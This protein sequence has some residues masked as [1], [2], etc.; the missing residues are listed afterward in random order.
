MTVLLILP[1]LLQQVKRKRSNTEPVGLLLTPHR[2]SSR[3][4]PI[5]QNAHRGHFFKVRK[6]KKVE[7][8]LSTEEIILPFT[9][10]V[11]PVRVLRCLAHK[12]L[13][14]FL[15]RSC[16][17]YPTHFSKFWYSNQTFLVT[18]PQGFPRFL[19]WPRRYHLERHL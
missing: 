7:H 16:S 19:G 15:H 12:P 18:F 9:R 5:G 11:I 1:K 2:I 6:K 17:W 3:T 14:V 8:P 10:W 13:H 4:F